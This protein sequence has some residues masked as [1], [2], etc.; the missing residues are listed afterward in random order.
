MLESDIADPRYFSEAQV[1]NRIEAFMEALNEK[2]YHRAPA[3]TSA[4]A[5][6]G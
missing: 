6:A 3:T 4:T 5:A 1:R 2:K